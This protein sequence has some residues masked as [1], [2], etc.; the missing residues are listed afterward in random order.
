MTETKANPKPNIWVRM[1]ESKL[2]EMCME[3]G[4]TEER[5]IKYQ[6]KRFFRAVFFSLP[7]IIASFFFQWWWSIIGFLIGGFL[8]WNE[9]KRATKF[10]NNFNFNKQLE[11][12]KF[13]RMIIPYLLQSDSTIYSV[14]S[15]MIERVEDGHLKGCLERLLIEMNEY[16]NADTPFVNFAKAASGTD[17]AVLFMT[18]LFD[19]QQ[20]SSDPTI[21]MELGQMSSEQLF[22][23]IDEIVSYKIRK[24]SFYPTKLTMSSF[25]VTLGYAICMIIDAFSNTGLS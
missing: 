15:K 1:A 3:M 14:F 22:E 7:L 25:V 8:W 17:S 9:Y 10:Y 4:F 6:K 16:P 2:Y 13:T 5:F 23:G 19:Y 24:F 11:Y 21:I 12:Q 20:S 18:T